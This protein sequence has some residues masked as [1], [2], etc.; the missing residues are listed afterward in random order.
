MKKEEREKEVGGNRKN[1]R[2][3]EKINKGKTEKRD[4]NHPKELKAEKE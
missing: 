3:E 2:K 4:N 1:K